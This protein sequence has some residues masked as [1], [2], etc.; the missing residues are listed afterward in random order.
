MA[1]RRASGSNTISSWSEG[2]SLALHTPSL[3]NGSGAAN[4]SLLRGNQDSDADG[5]HVSDE[6]EDAVARDGILPRLRRRPASRRRPGSTSTTTPRTAS[7]PSSPT[8]APPQSTPRTAPT[9][10]RPA[11]APAEATA[12][13]LPTLPTAAA[14]SSAWRSGRQWPGSGHSSG[15]RCRPSGMACTPTPS[16]PGRP[17]PPCTATPASAEAACAS[18]RSVRLRRL[19]MPR[20]LSCPGRLLR[21]RRRSRR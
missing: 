10:L 15:S 2:G 8:K 14:S 16:S 11:R 21:H 19:Q 17:R 7:C 1:S 4:A 9:L 13:P 12:G 18:C 20:R 6:A 3:S 5:G